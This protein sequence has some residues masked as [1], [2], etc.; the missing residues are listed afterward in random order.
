[1]KRFPP[2]LLVAVLVYVVWRALLLHLAFDQVAMTN[3]ELYPMGTLPKVLLLGADIPLRLYYDNAAGQLVTGFAGVP[4][5]AL[6]GDSWLVLKLVPATAGLG[7]LLCVWALLDRHA[8]RRAANIGALLFAVGP[9]ELSFKYSL[10][11]SG[12][13]FEN[14]FFTSLA[15]VC[16][17]RLHTTPEDH[18]RRWLAIAGFTQGL[19][20]FVFLG[21][22]IPVG[23]L[24]LVHLGLRGWRGTLRDLALLAP[25]GLV[26]MAPLIVL[27][28]LSG[29][30]GLDFLLAKFAS[31]EAAVQ[32]ARRTPGVWER[33][34]AFL[35]VELPRA[36][37]HTPVGGVSPRLPN[38]AL[39]GCL[40]VAWAAVLPAALRGVWEGA[41]GALGGRCPESGRP[42][43]RVLV[44]PF[45][46]YLPL[47]AL[48]YGLAD[49]RIGGHTPPVAVAGFRYFLPTFLFGGVL[50]AVV[51]DRWLAAGG[52]R[53]GLGA[54]LVGVALATGAWNAGYLR[55]GEPGV[56]PH[57]PGWN[58]VQAAKGLYNESIGL[59]HDE[60]VAI[61]DRL[62]PPFRNHMFRGL[63][64][65]ETQLWLVEEC[66]RSGRLDIEVLRSTALPIGA[67]V[68]RY[69][70]DVRLDVARGAGLGLRTYVGYGGQTAERLG[71][72]SDSL[73][74][75]VAGGSPWAYAVVEGAAAIQDFP[76]SW[77]HV[78]RVLGRSR[79]LLA[80]LPEGLRATYGRGLGV[81]C[82]RLLSREIPA[83]ERFLKGYLGYL[84]GLGREL[85][86][87]V[88]WGLALEAERPRVTEGALRA[89]P[90]G[91]PRAA[92]EEG[93]AAGLRHVQGRP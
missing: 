6:F 48:A 46:L 52:A 89:V 49:L 78:P 73:V 85:W 76:L 30:R 43:E 34:R 64:F 27:N 90:E 36:G 32:A 82:G 67:I 9:A 61:A 42:L 81:V 70:E 28:V 87:G 11:A 57:Y 33:M 58:F 72:V 13:H 20:I 31:S 69:P 39:L 21:A 50:V 5:Y 60:R 37:F 93:F 3:Y 74:M 4:C 18:R 56:G 15:I 68:E 47:T 23:L 77:Y 53:R 8:S 83:E 91:G 41:R 44:A 35:L 7:A 1:M 38:L 25:A 71:I 88:G 29:G 12:N 65:T 16:A 17:Y 79:A 75:T 19:A 10:L 92:L 59:T 22:I 24:A 45:A 63:G 54:A 55:G 14:L 86:L 84:G 51:G 26:G 80:M 2:G 40:A 66:G 62:P